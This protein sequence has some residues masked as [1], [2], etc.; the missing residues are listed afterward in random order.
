MLVL[1][2]L[3]SAFVLWT[4]AYLVAV[5]GRIART[6]VAPKVMFRGEILSCYC[7]EIH[8]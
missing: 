3:L 1:D 2:T 7:M 4:S 5:L 8:C 6:I